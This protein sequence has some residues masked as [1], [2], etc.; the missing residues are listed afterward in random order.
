MGIGVPVLL[1]ISDLAAQRCSF[2]CLN[3][4]IDKILVPCHLD[5]KSK[6]SRTINVPVYNEI[7][8]NRGLVALRWYAKRPNDWEKT[9]LGGVFS[10]DW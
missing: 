8:A 6:G 3:D 1:M 5:Y 2:V 7:G 4:Y 10:L 9:P